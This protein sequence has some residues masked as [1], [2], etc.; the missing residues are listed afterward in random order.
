[1]AD[2]YLKLD[3]FKGKA[4]EIAH[5]DWIEVK[6]FS[7]GLSQVGSARTGG[8]EVRMGDIQLHKEV[9]PESPSLAL[10][11]CTAEVLKEAVLDL[12]ESGTDQ[13]VYM[14]YTLNDCV[15]ASVT[16]GGSGGGHADETLSL[17]FQK[18]KWEYIPKSG[19]PE[20]AGWDLSKKTKQ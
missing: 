5:K 20:K 8:N 13:R 19:S 18:I 6:S 14:K 3:G 1:V 17:N 10:K 4:T 16:T 2:I 11:C 12:C 7:H 9:G 15:I